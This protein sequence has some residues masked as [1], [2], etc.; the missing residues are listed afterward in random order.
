MIVRLTLFLFVY[1]YLCY[2]ILLIYA[3]IFLIC[4]LLSLCIDAEIKFKTPA[5]SINKIFN[6]NYGKISRIA[7]LIS[8]LK[9]QEIPKTLEPQYFQHFLG[10]R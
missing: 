8:K 4:K 1:F 5:F 9:I 2:Y 10:R 3:N 6:I 7:I